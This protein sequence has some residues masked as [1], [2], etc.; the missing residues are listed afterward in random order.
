MIE[1]HTLE[2]WAREAI[3]QETQK[4]L[5]AL[6]AYCAKP[7]SAKR[8]HQARKALARLRAALQDLNELA[9]SPPAFR[10]RI[11]ELHRRAGKVRDADVQIQRIDVYLEDADREATLE[12]CMLRDAL[13][14][15]RAGA[16]R[17]LRRAL[18]SVPEIL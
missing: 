4:A 15:R 1:T 2:V 18:R 10:E 7:R 9:G 6:R 13:R 14:E 11:D 17:K 12:L 3:S 5:A 16:R 8:L